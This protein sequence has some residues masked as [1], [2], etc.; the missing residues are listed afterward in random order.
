[1]AEKTKNHFKVI[2]NR[3]KGGA[4]LA[5]HTKTIGE[6]TSSTHSAWTTLTKAKKWCAE[7]IGRS[8][9]TWEF[10]SVDENEKPMSIKAT[11]DTK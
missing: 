2:K 11:V 9:I 7:Q 1:M 5:S 10:V 4:W 6:E 8:R 3:E